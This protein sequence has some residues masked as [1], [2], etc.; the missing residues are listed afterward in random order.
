MKSTAKEI[1]AYHEAGHAVAGYRFGQ[2]FADLSINSLN[3]TE[4]FCHFFSSLSNPKHA[5]LVLLA[6]HA[7]EKHLCQ[8]RRKKPSRS[9][10]RKICQLTRSMSTSEFKELLKE[11]ENLVAANWHQIQAVAEQLLE[12]GTVKGDV[13]AKIIEAM[14]NDR[15]S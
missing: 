2:R 10:H 4:G 15:N 6:G 7:A 13:F 14:D 11:A 9:D 1:I 5:A 8:V 12:S 3:G